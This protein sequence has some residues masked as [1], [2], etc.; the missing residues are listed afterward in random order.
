MSIN[1][2]GHSKNVGWWWWRI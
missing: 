1:Y 2:L